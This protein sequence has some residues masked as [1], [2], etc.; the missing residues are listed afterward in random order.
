MTITPSSH[1]ALKQVSMPSAMTSGETS[2][3]FNPSVPMAMLS[4][5]V[6]VP[7]TCE[8]AFP[9]A[10]S[11]TAASASLCRP[12]LHGVIVEWTLATPTI[13]LSKSSSL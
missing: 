1:W 8:L 9:M 5:T 3:Y 4:E 10:I 6:G 2:E 11:A 12:A 7:S 13:G